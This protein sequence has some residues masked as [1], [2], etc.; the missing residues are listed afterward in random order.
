MSESTYILTP[1]GGLYRYDELRHHGIPGQKWGVRR[2]Q[3]KDGSLTAAGK[4]RRDKNQA[5]GNTA[6]TAVSKAPAN[7]RDH[8]KSD[9]SP[10]AWFV[11]RVGINLAQGDIVG[12]AFDTGR[13]VQA[14]AAYVKSKI[15]DKDREGCEKDATTGLLKKN[16][17]MTAEQDLAR[18][19][20]MV[21]NFDN[22][23]KNNCMLCT[24]AYDLRRRGFEVKARKAS[25]GYVED[26]VLAWYPDAKVNK[27]TGRN[28]KG[29]P[30]T[31]AMMTSVK[32]ELI[33]Q[34]EGARGNLMIRWA[35]MS[36]G[37]S[38]AYEVTGGK[39]RIVDAQVNKI[40]NNPDM[41]LYRCHN[42]VS[43]ARLDNIQPDP[44]TIRE[45]AE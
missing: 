28:E 24:A 30:S 13:A 27:V 34:G 15:Y 10:A 18:V 29:K 9:K 26:D 25:Q 4:K 42:E 23:T 38:V 43:Y 6:A 36:G 33:K 1:D 31:K 2:F 35:N 16:R 37:H 32:N 5:Y 14:G 3:N 21:H 7:S 17:T 45:V 12:L 8:S 20:P 41:F 40:Y 19:N 11:A 44:K 22:N 39:L